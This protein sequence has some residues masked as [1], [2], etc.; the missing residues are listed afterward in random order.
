MADDIVEVTL[1]NGEAVLVKA[2][3]V[4]GGGATKTSL[5]RFDLSSVSSTL[6]GVAE[7]VRAG[8]TRAAP[9]KVSVELSMEF[10]IKAGVLTALIVDSESSGS[11]TVTLE[12]ERGDAGSA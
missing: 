4:D 8:L 6:E 1:P 7:A 5:G 9:T 11:L 3:D 12:W 2:V 10:A